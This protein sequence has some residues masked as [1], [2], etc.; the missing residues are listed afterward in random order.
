[1]LRIVRHAPQLA[2]MVL[3]LAAPGPVRAQFVALDRHGES[4]KVEAATQLVLLP[5]QIERGD[6]LLVR[7]DLFLQ[8]GAR[9]WA[10]YWFGYGTMMF[11]TDLRGGEETIPGNLELGVVW[12]LDFPAFFI[13]VRFGVAIPMVPRSR[14]ADGRI[15]P[16]AA[17]QDTARARL[18]DFGLIFPQVVTLRVGLGFLVPMNLLVARADLGVDVFIPYGDASHRTDVDSAFRIGLGLGVQYKLFG[19]AV[20]WVG[21]VPAGAGQVGFSVINTMTV[22]LRVRSRWVQ[23]TLAMVAA[24]D[25]EAGRFFAVT[26]GVEG[27]FGW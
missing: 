20:E 6:G 10:G 3:L 8:A 4:N 5:K 11:A 13:P 23:P 18:S 15:V 21:V 26:A 16:P 17:L 7:G 19:A 25:D 22:S 2:A 12:C 9:G 1:M 24:L 14:D 27:R